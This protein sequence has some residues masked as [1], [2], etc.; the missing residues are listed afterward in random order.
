MDN[1]QPYSNHGCFCPILGAQ[2]VQ[3][4]I[5]V[6]ACRD[7]CDLKTFGDFAIGQ[8]IG[9]QRDDF[10]FPLR[11]VVLGCRFLVQSFHCSWIFE[12]SV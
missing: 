5:H 9:D 11:Q 6:I 8:P 1:P 2:F 3:D 10:Q 12:D 4:A 7:W